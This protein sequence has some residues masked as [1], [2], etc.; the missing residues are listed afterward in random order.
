MIAIKKTNVIRN[1]ATISTMEGLLLAFMLA[2]PLSLAPTNPSQVKSFLT[3]QWRRILS[4]RISLGDFI[5]AQEVRLGSYS[6]NPSAVLP[7]AAIV[8]S[9]A[10]RRDPRAE[11]KHR[12]RVPYVIAQ[13]VP[14][15][16]GALLLLRCRSLPFLPQMN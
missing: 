13:G 12:E 10:M 7:P 16:C 11:P 15:T 1:G 14:G 6:T 5:F 3:S 9:K 8:A 2:P 4:A